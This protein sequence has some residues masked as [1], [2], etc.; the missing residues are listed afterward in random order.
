MPKKLKYIVLSIACATAVVGLTAAFKL[1]SRLGQNIEIVVNMMRDLSLF[2]VDDVNSDDLLKGAASGMTAALDPYTELIS[3]DR[4]SE[5]E[6]MTTG[7]YGGIGSIIRADSDY[8]RIAEPYKG[9]PADRAGLQIGDK[10]VAV[11]GH[12]LKGATTAKVSSM[13]KGDPGTSLRLTVRKFYTS[14]LQTV[15]IKRERIALPAIP[16][17]VMLNDSVG[18]IYHSDFTDGCSD[19]MRRAVMDLKASGAK[20]LVLDYRSNGGGI[21]QEAVKILSLFVPDDTEV[22]SM[23]GR[24]EGTS[25]VFRTDGEP[26]A[27]DMPL[28][29]LVDG[30][31]ASASEILAG[32]VQD[33]D[34]GVIIGTRTFGKG[35][36][37]STRPMG[38]DSYLKL[39]TAKYYTP[40]GRC[41]QS[42]DYSDGGHRGG[43]HIADSLITEYATRAGRKVYDGGGITPD[44]S[45][46]PEY[47][48]R[49]A[50]TVYAK[51]LTDGFADAYCYD[52]RQAV[53]VETFAVSD[54]DYADFVK[55]VGERDLGYESQ[56]AAALKTL[57]SSVKEEGYAD[58]D[59]DLASLESKL[60]TDNKTLLMRHKTE[61]KTYIE[62][63]ILLRKVY[64][65]GVTRHKVGSDKS[66]ARAAAI[67]A[68]RQAYNTILTERDTPRD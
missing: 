23:R 17:F 43:S 35:L 18:Y 11:D 5:F 7:K 19:D 61:L 63:A 8:V 64:A 24:G 55:Y 31:T 42:F 28:A 33:L 53:D 34:R 25:K 27:A 32:A 10:I 65:D 58:A 45:I 36:V 68:D 14:E 46:A 6:L 49:F 54:A 60:K 57:R 44:E 48:S 1:P 51:G 22:V 9:S 38:Y 67:V 16:Y 37:Q 50:M 15:T 56:S 39:T 52:H 40:S 26:V 41:I 4:M 62:D 30:Y 47:V 29:I 66:I 21:V 20:S 3:E 13:L 12:D 59:S 2:Y